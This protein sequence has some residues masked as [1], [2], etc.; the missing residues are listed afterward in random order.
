M[1]Q[2]RFKCSICGQEHIGLPDIGC[3]AP[4]H[5]DE[6]SPEER[7]KSFKLTSDTCVMLDAEGTHYFV[8]GILLVPILAT[9][10]HFGWGVWV[11]LSEKNFNR[12]LSLKDADEIAKEPAYFGWF[13]N[14]IEGYP[15]TL[16][17]KTS[18]RLQPGNSRPRITLEPTE[19]PLAKEHHNGITIKR[20]L[21]LV[22][23]YL[24][25][26]T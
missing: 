13:S 21:E 4:V 25:P 23:P 3:R 7:E 20:T 22:R 6:A 18:V 9:T 5:Y 24:H 2:I 10:E 16:G 12:Y 14:R 8:R 1:S 17:L 26:Q 11:S 15:D 19:H